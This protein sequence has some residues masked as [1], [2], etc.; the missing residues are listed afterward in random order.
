MHA[1]RLSAGLQNVLGRCN[2][3]L[4]DVATKE[5]NAQVLRRHGCVARVRAAARDDVFVARTGLGD[6]SRAVVQSADARCP[7]GPSHS[8]HVVQ[9][10][11][12]CRTHKQ[13]GP[14]CTVFP[15]AGSYD[16]SPEVEQ[17]S[18]T[19]ARHAKLANSPLYL[20]VV[21]GYRCRI[22]SPRNRGEQST[23]I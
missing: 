21:G 3:Q 6:C 10:A 2:T 14:L 22:W 13:H 9:L 1:P 7:R 11:L 16:R 23:S 5:E 19:G 15:L 4:R 18:Q 17:V 20:R 12:R 8:L